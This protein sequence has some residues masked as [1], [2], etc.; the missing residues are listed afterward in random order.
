LAASRN[1]VLRRLGFGEAERAVLVHADDLGLCPAT[2]L[3]FA[4]LLDA[5]LVATG[6]VMVPAPAFCDVSAFCSRDPEA[7]VGVHLTLT[8]EWEETR[9][10]PVSTRDP[11]TG[12]VDADGG[13]PARSAVV[14]AGA[15]LSALRREIDAQVG[16]ARRAGIDV[17]HADAHMLALL[18]PRLLPVYRQAA[19]RWGLPVPLLEPA[20]DFSPL[21][22]LA[23][24]AFGLLGRGGG[25]GPAVC[26][27][28]V[29]LRLKRPEDR[30]GQAKRLFDSLPPGLTQLSIHPALDTPELRAIAP[31]WRCR[32]ADWEAFRSAELR[33][34]VARAGIRVI[35]YRAVRKAMAA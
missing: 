31:D 30:I 3:A 9:W 34:H 2:A 16:L 14:A 4:D 15:D 17:T 6:S 28:W 29:T 21:A 23:A 35:G 10:R 26:D 19:E 13:F 11:A 33:D 24:E 22:G 8:C 20:G 5:G 1:P 7:D 32:V 25:T 18:S 12:L 27:H